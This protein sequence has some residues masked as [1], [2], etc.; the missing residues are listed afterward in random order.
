[1]LD[2]FI[3]KFVTYRF[4]LLG[5][6]LLIAAP[7]T[8][9]ALQ[10]FI[11]NNSLSVWFLETDPRIKDYWLFQDTFGNDEVI[12]VML[13]DSKH[14]IFDEENILRLK[15]MEKELEEIPGVFQVNSIFSV[16]DAFDTDEGVVFRRLSDQIP[17][18]QLKDYLSKSSYLKGRLINEDA[19]LS[20]ISIRMD[21]NKDFDTIRDQVIRDVN[22]VLDKY[23]DKIPPIVG[24]GV[25]YS[26]LNKYTEEDIA[27]LGMIGYSLMFI[28]LGLSFR[29]VKFVFAAL[30]IV[31]I[32]TLITLGIL[33]L[34]GGQIN[35]ITS[36]LP[37]VIMVLGI[38]D[39]IHFPSTFA[40][41]RE[42]HPQFSRLQVAS[43]SIVT[44]FWPC[45]LTTLTTDFG[46]LSLAAAPM[47]AIRE[48]GI[49]AGIG[50]LVAF[51]V[52]IVLMSIFYIGFGR[53]G[54]S[55]DQ[56]HSEIL[57]TILE[58]I[59][60][61]VRNHYRLIV[62]I[63]L[64]IFFFFI[65]LL[66]KL[67]AD[68]YTLGY[69]ADDSQ[70]I[71]DHKEVQDKWG[72]YHPMEYT[73]KRADEDYIESA[74]TLIKLEAFV[75]EVEALEN[76]GHSFSA[77]D[78]YRRISVVMGQDENQPWTGPIVDQLKFVLE[79]QYSNWDM[80][81]PEYKDNVSAPV[82]NED[83]DLLR[84]TFGFKSLSGDNADILRAKIENIADRIFGDDY[85]V[86]LT[87]YLPLYIKIVSYAV[88]SQIT[89]FSI[90]MIGIFFLMVIWLKSLRLALV[91]LIP[92]LFPVLGIFA[93]M[94]FFGLDI[95]ITTATIA[96]IVIG[97]AVDDTVHF[98]YRW[99]QG[100]MMGLS[101]EET[102]DYTFKHAGKAALI[103]SLILLVSYPVLLLGQVKTIQYFGL[104]MSIAAGLALIADLLL[105]PSLLKYFHRPKK[106]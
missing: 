5:L 2:R 77:L 3:E 95:D 6:I 9:Y 30:S 103:T 83:R 32:S 57:F 47:A 20:L 27:T 48:L 37:S 7:L 14:N 22:L 55:V 101:W 98:L 99:R 16:Q 64:P 28:M 59:K 61:L 34:L 85:V 80:D 91:S 21:S 104:L 65:V 17:N 38:A 49:Y 90:A 66:F 60:Y 92:N 94:W 40:Y 39:A 96:A 42:Q 87:G 33:G 12:L 50:V 25:V 19:S 71:Q 88:E 45:L 70:E 36:V 58:K 44:V 15:K 97:V 68:T 46:F 105:L 8:P 35:I 43:K 10:A 75:K 18:S 4:W 54:K 24:G 62:L 89:S 84:I 63:F 67:E 1:M 79:S 76:I 86:S 23:F 69:L 11:P 52:S 41:I 31:V 81:D 74:E 102:L 93:T 56:G 72:Y 29:S 82:I 100:E 13:D 53:N 26:G 51:F 78:L 106:G 73:I